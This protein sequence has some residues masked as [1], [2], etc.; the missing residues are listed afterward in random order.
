MI[1]L[2]WVGE[3]LIYLIFRRV[4][5][6]WL[7]VRLLLLIRLVEAWVFLAVGVHILLLFEV[8]PWLLIR[9]LTIVLSAA[10]VVWIFFIALV[11]VLLLILIVLTV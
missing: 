6:F 1:L 3:V 8:I 7:R 9:C 5:V 2:L 4:R 10:I 11:V